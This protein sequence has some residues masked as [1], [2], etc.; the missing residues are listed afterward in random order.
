MFGFGKK[1][2][3]EEE[4]CQR[5]QQIEDMSEEDAFQAALALERDY[6]EAAAVTLCQAYFLGSVVDQDFERSAYYAKLALRK[7]QDYGSQILHK[8]PPASKDAQEKD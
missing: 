7:Y 8:V 5:I 4:L 2:M 3:T 6:P 1:R